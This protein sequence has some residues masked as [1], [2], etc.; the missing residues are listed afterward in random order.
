LQ[1]AQTELLALLQKK[2]SDQNAHLL[3]GLI[4]FDFAE[5][6]ERRG[7]HDEATKLLQESLEHD[8]DSAYALAALAKILGAQG[9]LDEAKKECDRAAILS[10]FDSRLLKGCGLKTAPAEGREQ[11]WTQASPRYVGAV[12]GSA[13]RV[14]P[15]VAISKPDP[16]YSE[17]A[18]DAG[19]QG[20]V[21]LWILVSETGDVTDTTVVKPL[22]M[23]LDQN[24]LQKVRTW[25]FEPARLNGVPVP[26]K[27]AVEVSFR[28]F[29]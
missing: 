29:D 19:I 8:P 11:S 7:N 20:T 21:V 4:L 14:T 9:S 27:V 13:S 28:L 24:A 22:G 25:K 1:G 18:R 10:P 17:E 23:F 26:V 12:P 6:S 16:E 5:D 3:L 2:P 15:P